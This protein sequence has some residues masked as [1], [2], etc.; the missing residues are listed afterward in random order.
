MHRVLLVVLR[1]RASLISGEDKDALYDLFLLFVISPTGAMLYFF[2]KCKQKRKE[3]NRQRPQVWLPNIPTPTYRQCFYV[4]TASFPCSEKGCSCRWSG[5]QRRE[6]R[7]AK[8]AKVNEG[9]RQR[10]RGGAEGGRME[11]AR[12]RPGVRTREATKLRD[13]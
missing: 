10:A 9:R 13:R 11:H 2:L 8:D 5:H 6:R 12:V 1:L 4:R 3:V 7:A